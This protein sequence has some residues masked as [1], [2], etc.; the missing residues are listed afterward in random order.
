MSRFK[1]KKN[2]TIQADFFNQENFEK[3]PLPT[4]LTEF[5]CKLVNG[6]VR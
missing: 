1:I 2:F 5:P 6:T 4:F 3:L